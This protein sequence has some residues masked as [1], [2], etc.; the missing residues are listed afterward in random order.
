MKYKKIDKIQGFDFGTKLIKVDH[1]LNHAHDC[2]E[3]VFVVKGSIN[4]QC[5][6]FQYTLNEGDIYIINVKEMHSMTAIESDNLV[7]I[8]QFDPYALLNVFAKLDY[9]WFVCGS[10]HTTEKELLDVLKLRTFLS[11]IY[12][13]VNAEDDFNPNSVKRTFYALVSHLA[14]NF[15]NFFLTPSG[16][17][18]R[19]SILNDTIMQ[20]RFF[21]IQEYININFNKKITLEDVA[22]HLSLSTYY[23]SHI[24][25]DFLGISFSDLVNIIRLEHSEHLLVYSNMPIHQISYECGFS[26]VRYYEKNFI[27]WFKMKPSA[28]RAQYIEKMNQNLHGYTLM[29]YEK[30]LYNIV[31]SYSSYSKSSKSSQ[32]ISH[33]VDTSAQPEHHRLLSGSYISISNVFEVFH[34]IHISYI[35]NAIGEFG[36][37]GILLFN[38]IELYETKLKDNCLNKSLLLDFFYQLTKNNIDFKIS[39]EPKKGTDL[40]ATVKIIK[41]FIES[42][43]STHNFY[44]PSKWKF[45][46]PNN[47]STDK[48]F[49]ENPNFLVK[50]KKE[51]SLLP[52]D[53][54]LEEINNFQ[55][56]EYSYNTTLLISSMVD[57]IINNP[58]TNSLSYIELFSSTTLSK[59]GLYSSLGNKN[60][61]YRSLNLISL[62]SPNIVYKSNGLVVTKTNKDYRI[63]VYDNKNSEFS[64]YV[65]SN[66]ESI[67]ISIQLEDLDHKKFVVSDIFVDNDNSLFNVLSSIDFPTSMTNEEMELVDN[68]TTP[69]T[70]FYTVHLDEPYF[71]T[72]IKPHTIR[73]LIL[74]W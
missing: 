28:Y 50:L 6:A 13:S 10:T 54:Q 68:A 33:R 63:L 44:K 14:D 67:E 35:K 60:P 11:E 55:K 37:K 24:V 5:N 49:K 15:Q 64:N 72:T 41:D 12:L 39:L 34:T 25:K 46:L 65:Y 8:F 73:L 74:K 23:L 53:I 66:E 1:I 38:I 36:F 47:S 43:E 61:I 70:S 58:S 26:A 69:K 17:R 4:I 59:N 42:F 30:S 29:P 71:T 21:L 3:I 18:K 16:Y 62:L 22:N 51:L 32:A 19:C 27:K 45:I 48:A 56:T 40:E 20:E 57:S 2:F 52:V 9:Y 31:N 7:M